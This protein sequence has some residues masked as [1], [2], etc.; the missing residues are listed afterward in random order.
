VDSDS[1]QEECQGVSQVDLWD[2]MQLIVLLHA[3]IH[4]LKQKMGMAPKQPLEQPTP[5]PLPENTDDPNQGVIIA[6]ILGGSAILGIATGCLLFRKKGRQNGDSDDDMDSSD[7]S[8]D[9]SDES[10]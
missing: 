3:I 9:S 6:A 10:D 2:R 5:A 7:D 4:R 1:A 8:S